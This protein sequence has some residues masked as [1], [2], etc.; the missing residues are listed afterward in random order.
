MSAELN[1]QVA[2]L[3]GWSDLFSPATSAQDADLLID[4]LAALGWMITVFT[5]PYA[6][7][8]FDDDNQAHLKIETRARCCIM[9]G[10]Q[11]A[12]LDSVVDVV[13]DTRPLAIC[14]AFIQAME[15]WGR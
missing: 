2:A 11:D 12:I 7:V 15:K 4:R 10:P 6:R 8:V 5:G 13:A 3:T 9:R 14:R 1:R